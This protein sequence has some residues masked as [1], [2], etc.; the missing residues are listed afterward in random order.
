MRWW[1]NPRWAQSPDDATGTAVAAPV[2]VAQPKVGDTGANATPPAGAGVPAASKKDGGTPEKPKSMLSAPG[3][4]QGDT[5]KTVKETTKDGDKDAGAAET[6]A[7]VK[8]TLPEKLPDGVSVDKDFVA[9]FEKQASGL[10]LDSET[11]SKL[12]GWYIDEQAKANTRIAQGLKEWSAEQ[13]AALEKDPEFGGKNLKESQANVQ[14]ALSKFGKSH[15]LAERLE[16]LGLENDPA[17]IKTL[18]AVG[19]AISEDRSTTDEGPVKSVLSPEEAAVRKRYPTLY[20]D[21]K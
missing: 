12:V 4:G 21:K 1:T 18:A 3:D 2:V 15:G 7:P 19:K 5:S 10:K 13:Y 11:A 8:V 9:E 14:K 16:A 20:A 6:P 17:I